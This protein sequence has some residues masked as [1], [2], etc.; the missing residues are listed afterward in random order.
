MT[1]RTSET[2]EIVDLTQVNKLFQATRGD[3]RD[4]DWARTVEGRL[5]LDGVKLSDATDAL[6]ALLPVLEDA[7]EPAKDLFGDPVLWARE[8]QERW[9]ESGIQ[10]YERPELL[11]AGRFLHYTFF[12]A[13]W[14]TVAMAIVTLFSDGWTTNLRWTMFSLPLV[15]SAAAIGVQQVWSKAARTSAHVT[16]VIWT[17]AFII[18][19]AF[20]A[21]G[22]A[23][24][25]DG[26][27]GTGSALWYLTPAPIYALLYWV[28]GIVL[29]DTTKRPQRYSSDAGEPTEGEWI[30]QLG[31]HLRL[32]NDL[33]DR[34]I[35]V[36]IDETCAYAKEAGTS[37]NGEFGTSESYAASFA[38]NTAYRARRAAWGWTA[39]SSLVAAL[40][41]FSIINADSPLTWQ[42]AIFAL[43]LTG[44]LYYMVQ[45]WQQAAKR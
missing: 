43:L 45:S 37:L 9:H 19:V 4:A 30:R 38:P 18:G 40:L 12:G 7:H 22:L 17:A 16:A 44:T 36:I 42:A 27:A 11:S 29:K 24:V 3:E 28:S 20:A 23:T 2:Q 1:E 34:Q 10:A 15:I 25:I 31:E 26:S 6:L 14:V 35:R 21:A 33:S 39:G 32:R 41:T 5:M 8:Q 13:F